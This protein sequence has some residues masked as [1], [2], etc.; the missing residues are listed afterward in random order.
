MR[1]EAT[2]ASVPAVRRGDALDVAGLPSYGFAH[3]SLMWWGNAGMMTIEG[4]AFAFMIVI[5]FYLRGLAPTWPDGGRA[6]DLLWGT[7]NLAVIVASIL[8]NWLAQRAA[9]DR[10][11]LAVRLWLYVCSAFGI[12]LCGVRWLEFK[13]LNVRWD[14][15]AY[16]SVVW[17]LLGF[18]SFNL[19][20]DVLDTFVL[21]AVTYAK[22][23]EGKRF[24]DIA[25]NCGYWYFVVITWLPIYAVLY[26]G[27]RF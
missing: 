24:V 8:P 9:L 17:V 20:T 5:Y 27:A 11:L 25:E 22:P 4:V 23:L 19:V 6:P 14:E 1:R 21:T 26:F 3:R 7:V 12:A 15:G 13:R 16:G 10:D 18:H 2:P